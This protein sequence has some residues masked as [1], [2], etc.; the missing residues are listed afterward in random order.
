M[1]VDEGSPDELLA[2]EADA[3]AGKLAVLLGEVGVAEVHVDL[4]ARD[5]R[6]VGRSRRRGI[7]GR[8]L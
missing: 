4:G 6:H 2:H 7:G 8:L 1:L 5:G 3:V